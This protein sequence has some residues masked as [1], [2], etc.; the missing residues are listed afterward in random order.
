MPWGRDT[1]PVR[2]RVRDRTR[3]ASAGAGLAAPAGPHPEAQRR[4][5][6]ETIRALFDRMHRAGDSGAR[7]LLI[8]AHGRLVAY[9]ARKFADRGQPLE[10]LI[11][12]AQIGLIKAI[13]RYETSRGVEFTTYATPVI[14]GEIK[15]Y[16]RDKAWSIRVPRRLRALNYALMRSLDGIAQRL[17]RSPTIG[18]LAQDA[19]IPFDLVLEALEVG[20]AYTPASLDAVTTEDKNSR[21]S[22]CLAQA[23]GADDAMLERVEDRITLERAVGK[24]PGRERQVVRMT[25]YE[26]LT[27]DAIARRLGISQMHVSRLRRKALSRLRASIAG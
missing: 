17:G 22:F 21:E 20:Q 3:R 6:R 26:G 27:Q 10:D 24:L 12:V 25:F 7:D 13:D 19:G 4:L 5:D 2:R 8:L 23:I 18:E 11:Q 15:R 14:V 9:L 1:S 16:F